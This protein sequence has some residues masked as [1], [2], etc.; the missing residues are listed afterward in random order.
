MPFGGGP[1]Q[2]L[3]P[4]L[5]NYTLRGVGFDRAGD[6]LAINPV[7]ADGFALYTIDLAAEPGEPRLLW[8]DRWEVQGAIL[9]ANG[10]IAACWSTAKAKGVRRYTLLAFDTGTGEQV[11]ELDDGSHARVV[12]VRFSP[13]DGDSRILAATTRSGYVRPVIWDPRSGER[14]EIELSGLDGDV[15]PLDWSHDTRQILVTRLARRT[16]ASD[17]RHRHRNTSRP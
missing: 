17:G 11:G 5:P 1:A 14:H 3:T 9:S 4:A 2:D 13:A 6:L 15:Q 10:D 16:V 7:N 8:R 12:G